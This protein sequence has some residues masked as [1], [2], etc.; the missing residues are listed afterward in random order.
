MK[1]AIFTSALFVLLATACQKQDSELL[2]KQ[3]AQNNTAKA[4]AS[5]WQEIALGDWQRSTDANGNA[6]YSYQ[7][8]SPDLANAIAGGGTVLT[9]VKGYSFS[10]PSINKPMQMP[11]SFFSTN[12]RIATPYNWTVDQKPDVVTIGLTMSKDAEQEF[13]AAKSGIEFRYAI[14]TADQLKQL[15]LSKEGVSRL[16]YNQLMSQLGNAL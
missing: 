8:S 13:K 11:F 16:G 9:F 1:C 7:L 3:E 14:I 2:T 12:E 6:A 5:G 10:E 15:G 4:S